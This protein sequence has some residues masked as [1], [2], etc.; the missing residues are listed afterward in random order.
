MER[1]FKSE[2]AT[3]SPKR[4]AQ[5]NSAT[6]TWRLNNPEAIKEI[7]KKTDEKRKQFRREQNLEK[8]YGITYK[9]YVDLLESQSGV[10]CICQRP[11][12]LLGK[13]GDIRPLNVD[14]CHATGKVRGLLCAS[15]NLALGNLEDNI[16][17]FENAI[18]YLKDS[19][20]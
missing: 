8:K 10:C 1:N 12:R 15:C 7:R 2:Y 5:L 4:K 6:K 3:A 19:N 14:H 16:E 11:E 20:E 13:G 18:Q 9:E 17:Y